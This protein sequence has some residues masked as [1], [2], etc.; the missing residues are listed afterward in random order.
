MFSNVFTFVQIDVD[1]R[2]IGALML[3]ETPSDGC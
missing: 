1:I 3:V 2:L